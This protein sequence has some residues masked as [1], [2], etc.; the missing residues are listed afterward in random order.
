MFLNKSIYITGL[1]FVSRLKATPVS[2][3]NWLCFNVQNILIVTTR[4]IG[5]SRLFLY[6]ILNSFSQIN[7][8]MWQS[9][10]TF[11]FDEPASLKWCLAPS[12]HK[13]VTHPVMSI[14][15]GQVQMHLEDQLISHVHPFSIHIIWLCHKVG[16]STCINSISVVKSPSKTKKRKIIGGKWL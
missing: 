9:F 13:A 15:V 5:L 12:F 6:G 11:N 3:Q 2:N 4:L 10:K 1:C 8:Y 16:K 14:S 7:F